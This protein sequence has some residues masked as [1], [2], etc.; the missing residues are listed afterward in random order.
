MN[1]P[2]LRMLALKESAAM[3]SRESQEQTRRDAQL[4]IACEDNREFLRS[5]PDESMKL[6]VTSPPY[7]LGKRYET[8]APLD[9]YASAWVSIRCE[10]LSPPCA[11]G[12]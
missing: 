9:V 6:I 10:S 5:L 4:M 3:T 12:R 7:N 8:R 1:G 11:L 2:S